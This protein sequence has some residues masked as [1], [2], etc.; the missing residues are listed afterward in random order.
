[1]KEERSLSAVGV[2]GDPRSGD[3]EAWK[4]KEEKIMRPH[5][6]IDGTVIV[7]QVEKGFKDGGFH[8]GISN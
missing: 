6:P 3:A 2:W 1:M 8:G 5:R 4:I 7:G